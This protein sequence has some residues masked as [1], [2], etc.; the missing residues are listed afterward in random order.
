MTLAGGWVLSGVQAVLRDRRRG[1]VLTL[2][3]VAFV[4]F[5][6]AP[7]VTD[8]GPVGVQADPSLAAYDTAVITVYTTRDGTRDFYGVLDVARKALAPTRMRVLESD[9]RGIQTLDV[10]KTLVFEG[11]VSVRVALVYV[12]DVNLVVVDVFGNELFRTRASAQDAW[13][14][15]S[16]V[17]AAV[18]ASLQEFVAA[19]PGFDPDAKTRVQLQMDNWPRGVNTEAAAR[20]TIEESLEVLDSVEGIWVSE[21]N[22]Y[23]LAILR[24]AEGPGE[25]FVASVLDSRVFSW[26]PGMVKMRLQGTAVAGNYVAEYYMA[27]LSRQGSTATVLDGRLVV[28]GLPD[29]T[30]G[31]HD[32]A[33]LQVYPV[34][35]N[36]RSERASEGESASSEAVISIGSGFLISESGLVVT[37]AHVIEG[38]TSIAVRLSEG[39]LA[40]SAKPAIIDR[41]NDLAVL[42]LQ[43]FTYQDHFQG[44]IPY[45]IGDSDQTAVG[46]TVY[47]VGFPLASLLGTNLRVTDGIISARTGVQDAPNVFQVSNPLQPG[48]S[49]GPLLNANGEIIG[50]LVSSLDSGYVLGR[51][52][53]LPQNVNFA[54]KSSYLWELVRMLPTGD[55]VPSRLENAG[56]VSA[57][58]LVA[59]I[60]PFIALI[61]A[62]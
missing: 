18:A 33:F 43:D 54:I 8:G 19:Y 48:N 41:A 10:A 38:A 57:R 42:E 40:F 62:E 12:A 16:A 28:R 2:S 4:L 6:C 61:E 58:A 3:L 45:T 60:A 1:T 34:S 29:G 39:A 49:G 56:K 25:R 44:P 20:E 59:R 32:A 47:A 27:N 21:D 35:P 14:V 53:A 37:N 11:T 51:S 17:R 13:T 7:S 31:Y 26:V 50:I 23:R 36:S 22:D 15:G 9:S 5:G 46:E 55:A 30:G 24:D 52:G